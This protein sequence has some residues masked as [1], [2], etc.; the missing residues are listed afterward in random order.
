MDIM[1]VDFIN[2][3]Q[4]LASCRVDAI[5]PKLIRDAVEI[6]S[7]MIAEDSEIGK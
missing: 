1:G 5:C 4:E 2:G 3:D 6:V 7:R